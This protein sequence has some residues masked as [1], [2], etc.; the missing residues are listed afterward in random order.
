MNGFLR[1]LITEWR[2]LK[3]PTDERAI[4]TGVSGGADSLAL[5]F[6]LIELRR[7]EK[8]SLR[9]V[10]AHFNHRLRGDEANA[11]EEFVRAFAEKH[12]VELAVGHAQIPHE[13]NIEESARHERYAFLRKTA[14]N[15]DAFAVVTA[16]TMNDQAETFLL[17]LL[18]GS[19]PAGLRGMPSVR[20]FDKADGRSSAESP[21]EQPMKLVRPLLSWAKRSDTEQFCHEAEI[22]YRY[23]SMNED[24]NFRRVRIRKILL[25]AMA[26]FNPKI[27]ETLASTALLMPEAPREDAVDELA[28][29][30]TMPLA[31]LS[32]MPQDELYAC[33]RRWLKQRRGNLRGLT[34]KHIRAIERLILSRKSGKSV[35]IPGF[36]CVERQSGSLAYRDLKVE[37]SISAN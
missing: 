35:E 32:G 19:G 31:L 8:I 13:N 18:R 3:L 37:K 6:A 28:S 16:H 1:E 5:L 34:L 11:D 10:A 15:V 14:S 2:R 29:R 7:M 21:R 9:I 27:V 24:L 22:D 20:E 25:P 4:V 23:D 12:R 26:E 36:A 33:L 17:N 30:E